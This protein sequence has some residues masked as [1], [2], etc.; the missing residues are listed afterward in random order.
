MN[1]II[2]P[3]WFYWLH[4]IE[5]IR[6]TLIGVIFFAVVG[7]ILSVCGVF[8]CESQIKDFPTFSDG[9]RERLPK[10]RKLALSSIITAAVCAVLLVVIP[11]RTVII[12][13]MI[14]KYATGE[15][16]E[17][18]VEAIE[19]AVDYIVEAIGSMGG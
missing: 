10:W 6:A 19:S 18:T 16:A 1:Y 8:F 14:A 13:M 3:T 9:E 11:S 15:N 17:L 4:I 5:G 12:E 2:N 7:L